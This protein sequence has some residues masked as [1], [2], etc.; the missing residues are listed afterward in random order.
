V[1]PDKTQ[2]MKK[3]WDEYVGEGEIEIIDSPYRQLAYPLRDY[4]RKMLDEAPDSYV[5]VIMGHLAMDTFWEQALHQNSVLLFNVALTNME[6]VVVTI[7]PYQIH[8]AP[9]KRDEYIA[10][11]TFA[12][13]ITNST[14]VAKAAE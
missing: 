9:D 1:N 11:A 14:D 6:R 12:R 5:H 13:Q 2:E 8:R 3:E 10:P 7:V 4:I